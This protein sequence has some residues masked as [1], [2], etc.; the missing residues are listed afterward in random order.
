[1]DFC[2]EMLR[3]SKKAEKSDDGVKEVRLVRLRVGVGVDSSF[4][5]NRLV[6]LAG[7]TGA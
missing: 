7:P 4:D 2:F 6:R 1:M 3:L 5:T